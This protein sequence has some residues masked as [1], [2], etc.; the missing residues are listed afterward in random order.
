MALI[1]QY[2]SNMSS[3]RLNSADRIAGQAKVLGT[4]HTT[5]RFDLLFSVWS[6]SNECAAADIAASDSGQRIYGV[7]YEVPDFLISRESAKLH[8]QRSMDA[9][10]GEGVNYVRKEIRVEN[11]KG[12]ILSTTT[13]VVK[14]P[15]LGL[16]TSLPY[17][18]HILDG[19]NEHQLPAAYRAYVLAQ[20][21]QN[22]PA[23]EA[24]VAK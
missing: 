24:Q 21:V 14:D 18:T 1:F 11:A 16:K 23:L 4:G 13:Y 17:V 12:E 5:E 7:I 15:Q 20:I 22:N 9:I 8:G 6:K 19:L 10:E 2:G 3:E